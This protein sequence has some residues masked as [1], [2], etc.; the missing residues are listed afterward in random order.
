MLRDRCHIDINLGKLKAW[1]PG[2][3]DVPSGL[4]ALGA[5]VWCGVGKP[6]DQQGI[7]V[8]G[9]PI[10]TPEFVAEFGRQAVTEEAQ[11]LE[12]LPKLTSLQIAWLLLYFCA[13]P[14]INHLVRTLPPGLVSSIAEMHDKAIQDTFR[15]LFSIAEQDAWDPLLQRVSFETVMKQAALPLRLAGCG[16]RDSQRTAS[17]AYWASWADSVGEIQKRLPDVGQ[18]I[19]NVFTELEAGRA[20]VLLARPPNCLQAA[21][22]AGAICDAKGFLERPSWLE[23]ANGR[24]PPEPHSDEISLGEWMHGW[25]YHASNCLEK[26]TF[27][28]LLSDLA[29]PSHRVNAQAVGK[30]RLH[31][32]RG[33]FAASWLTPCPVTV[34]LTVEDEQ[35]SGLVRMRLG[36]AVCVDGPDAHGYYRLADNTGGRTNGRHTSVVASW[37][38][39][40]SEAG[41]EMT[42]RNVERLLSSTHVPV[43]AGSQLRMDLVVPG[44]NVAG[45]LPLF[46]DVT[47]VSPIT[48]AGRSRPGTSNA[49]GALLVRA[50]SQNDITYNV[51]TDSRLGALY[52]LGFEVFGRWGPQCVTLLPWLAH[53]KARGLHPRLRRGAALAYQQRWA[54]IVSVGLMKAVGA[55]ALRGEGADLVTTL[56]EP[57]PGLAEVMSV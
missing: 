48:R 34:T 31:S 1:S 12:K 30:T 2:A 37:R 9:T 19:I 44:L 45:G 17:A 41:R 10:G 43:P 50:Q 33:R 24:R 51:V 52:C 14:R 56:L 54:G 46:C 5:D 3:D 40:F 18:R 26:S 16:L 27:N 22:D 35:M 32:C 13:V 47:V 38:Q 55:A 57:E 36:L 11:L 39:V 7:K 20:E 8:L 28:S 23:L 42:D 6:V 29:Y 4:P 25:Q 15:V 53:E 21:E 49:G